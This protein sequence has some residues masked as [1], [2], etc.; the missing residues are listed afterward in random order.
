MNE[1]TIQKGRYDLGCGLARNTGKHDDYE[2]QNP[3]DGAQ[4]VV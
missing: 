1:K 4:T 2:Q 3:P